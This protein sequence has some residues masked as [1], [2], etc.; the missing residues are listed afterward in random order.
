MP[1]DARQKM[2]ESAAVLLAMR[3]VQ[4]TAFSDVLERS[5]APRGSIYHHFPLGKDELV[6]AAI[7]LAG[8]RALGVLETLHGSPPKAVTQAFIDLWRAVLVRSNMRAGCAVLAVTVGADSPDLLEH[9]AS[10]FRAWRRGL[11]DLYV[12]GGMEPGPAEQLATTLVAATE[13]AVVVSRAERS[14]D[15]F[16]LVGKHLLEATP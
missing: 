7:E 10:I 12:E 5:G 11:A 4:G 15:A 14:L 1:T 3:G 6:D 9:A 13:G 2:I 8:S 16:E